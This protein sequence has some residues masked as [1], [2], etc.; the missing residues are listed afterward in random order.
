MPSLECFHTLCFHMELQSTFHRWFHESDRLRW[1]LLYCSSRL[2]DASVAAWMSNCVCV[3]CSCPHSIIES[4][5][6]DSFLHQTN[7]SLLRKWV[8]LLFPLRSLAIFVLC[9]LC[10]V[11]GGP[12]PAFHI[13]LSLTFSVSRFWHATDFSS[14]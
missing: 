10:L 12:C 5:S 8:C 11:R 9:K 13:R 3:K 4:T 1:F 6:T 14:D 7:F 2:W